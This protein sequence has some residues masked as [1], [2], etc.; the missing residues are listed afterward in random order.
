MAGFNSPPFICLFVLIYN[1]LQAFRRVSPY[2]V[3]DIRKLVPQKGRA[4]SLRNQIQPFKNT[5]EMKK[6]L[7][8][9]ALMASMASMAYAGP[10]N[11]NPKV[12]TVC[13]LNEGMYGVNVSY[14]T[15]G[16]LAVTLRF[17]DAPVVRVSLRNC[18]TG[19]YHMVSPGFAASTVTVPVAGY[20]GT[21]E[22]AATCADGGSCNALFFIDNYP[23]GGNGGGTGNGD[24]DDQRPQLMP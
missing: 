7:F 4:I 5:R 17:I 20:L 12:N 2:Q 6:I 3:F 19:E 13:V 8:V 15:S 9:L 22:L 14:A 1:R 18:D 21:W 24:P 16:P 11:G 10:R 23:G